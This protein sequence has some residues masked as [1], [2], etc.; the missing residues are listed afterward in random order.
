MYADYLGG[1]LSEDRE[2]DW[3]L[4]PSVPDTLVVA[5]R[6]CDSLWTHRNTFTDDQ[7][8][9]FCSGTTVRLRKT[10]IKV[11]KKLICTPCVADR[12]CLLDWPILTFAAV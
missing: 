9:Q 5:R 6:V 2:D 3:G 8:D 1:I 12:H 10:L 4:D 11:L 7:L